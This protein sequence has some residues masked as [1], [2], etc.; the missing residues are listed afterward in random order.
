MDS[1]LN[2]A[3]AGDFLHLSPRERR[4]AKA[5]AKKRARIGLLK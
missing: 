2:S 3:T 1:Q 5:R 4:K